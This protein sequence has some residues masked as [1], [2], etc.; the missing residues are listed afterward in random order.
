MIVLEKTPVGALVVMK[1][2]DFAG[3]VSRMQELEREYEELR[4]LSRNE[5]K[6]DFPEEVDGK[7]ATGN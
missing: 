3:I 7:A 6:R 5:S 2:L 4:N 1:F